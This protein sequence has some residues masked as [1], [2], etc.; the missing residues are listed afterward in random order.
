TIRKYAL[1]GQAA[2]AFSGEP[3][4]ASVTTACSQL[5]AQSSSLYPPQLKPKKLIGPQRQQVRQ[6]ANARKYI[7]AEH[8]YQYASAI[9]LQIQFDRLRFAGKVVDRQY[10]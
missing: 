1:V 2:L 8:F 9:F 4:A 6:L 7:S 10:R 3:G 5:I